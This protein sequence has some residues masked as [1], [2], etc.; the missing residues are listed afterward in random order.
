MAYAIFVAELLARLWAMNF[1]LVEFVKNPFCLID[2]AVVALDTMLL[3]SQEMLK[4]MGSAG[5]YTKALRAVRL[6][7]LL[8]LFKAARFISA[9]RAPGVKRGFNAW[10]EEKTCATVKAWEDAD[11]AATQAYC[12]AA[13][14]HMG[15]L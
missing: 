11:A 4:E 3:A 2:F 6:L 1:D 13:F 7:R 12:T 8:R 10:H 14:G 9:V 15:P 5:G